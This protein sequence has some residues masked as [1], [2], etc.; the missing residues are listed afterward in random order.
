MSDLLKLEESGMGDGMESDFS[1]NERD[2]R[3]ALRTFVKGMSE[4]ER[5]RFLHIYAKYQDKG[6]AFTAESIKQ[7]KQIQY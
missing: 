4:D 3:E 7:Q 1:I 2:V 5:R 6:G